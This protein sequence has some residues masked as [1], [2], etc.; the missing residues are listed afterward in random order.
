L[1]FLK[2]VKCE[3]SNYAVNDSLTEDGN[4]R[5]RIQSAGPDWYAIRPCTVKRP[6]P[7]RKSSDVI[8]VKTL[9]WI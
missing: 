6:G 7:L 9:P 3:L 8:C 5:I 1:Q 4:K 2:F